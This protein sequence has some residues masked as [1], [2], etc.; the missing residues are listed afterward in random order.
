M[1]PTDK[2]EIINIISSLDPNK[3]TGPTKVIKLLKNDISQLSDI[4]NVSFLTGVFPSILKI[5]K[6]VPV[7]KKQSKLVYSNYHPISLSSNLEKIL[8]KL[9]YRRVFNFFNDSNSIYSLQFG[10]RQKYFTTHALISLAEDIRKNQDEGNIGCVIFVDLQKAF[11][12]VEHDVLLA[13]LNTMVSMVSQMSGLDPTYPT[14]SNM[15]QLI[16]MNQ[17]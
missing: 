9:M 16:V 3:S 12:T 4:F 2:Y 11:D 15:F 7:H 10:F 1:T 8:E 6:V 14:E 17:V 13:E 5:A